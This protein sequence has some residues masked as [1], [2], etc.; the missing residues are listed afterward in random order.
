MATSRPI[1]EIQ[2]ELEQAREVEAADKRERLITELRQVRA[3]INELRPEFR[4]RQK[5][6][7]EARTHEENRKR[8]LRRIDEDL[9]MHA[10]QR[11]AV[12][13]YLPGEP[14]CVRWCKIQAA[15]VSEREDTLA[16]LNKLP[17]ATEALEVMHLGQRLDGLQEREKM[18]LNMLDGSSG[19]W[20]STAE[21][22]F[23]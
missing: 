7:I 19:K 14:E 15:L 10:A 22:R 20:P 21:L 13:D 11:P 6:V 9:G 16:A 18:L 5:A 3:Q 8:K 2:A 1:R 23:V 4:R 17:P 12:F